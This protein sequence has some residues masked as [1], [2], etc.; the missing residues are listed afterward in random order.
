MTDTAYKA[1]LLDLDGTLADTA[2]DMATAINALRVEQGLTPM[3]YSL[4]RPVVSHGAKGLLALAFGELDAGREESLRKRFV[5][6][7]ETKLCVGTKLFPG[8]TEV[9]HELEA[10]SVLWGVVT[11][12]PASLTEP[13]P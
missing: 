10:W 6:L 3:P 8:F 2:P 4:I 9:L 5:S 1:V 12:K 11:N 7:Y 13:L